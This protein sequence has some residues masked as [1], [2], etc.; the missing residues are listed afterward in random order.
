MFRHE[1]E[2]H[3]HSKIHQVVQITVYASQL[4][5][6]FINAR[7]QGLTDKSCL[8]VPDIKTQLNFE[9]S[10]GQ[11]NNFT[12][13]TNLIQRRLASTLKW[14]HYKFQCI[15][16]LSESCFRQE[17]ERHLRS[18]IRWFTESCN[19]HHISQLAAFFVDPR[20]KRFATE[21]CFTVPDIQT[22]L[23][24]EIAN[25]Q[26]NSFTAESDLILR[27]LASA[28]KWPHYKFTSSEIGLRLN[29]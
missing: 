5:S 18:K 23:N 16:Q 10:N 13:Q 1:R 11:Q 15:Y 28:L 9:I 21:S 19:S 17:R 3:F 29:S 8:W 25:G 7:T 12:A 27:R 26:Q 24:F 2:H 22:Q 4:T 6:F 14:P 20:T